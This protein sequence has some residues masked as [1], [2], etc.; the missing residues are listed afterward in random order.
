[1]DDLHNA[2]E[3][4]RKEAV[5]HLTSTK[6][7]AF[8]EQVNLRLD[9]ASEIVRIVAAC[10][11]SV[12][13]NDKVRSILKHR[14]LYGDKEDLSTFFIRYRSAVRL[15]ENGDDEAIT[16]LN[17]S[18]RT[19]DPTSR[20]ALAAE[21]AGS[22]DKRLLPCAAAMLDDRYPWVV[23]GASEAAARMGSVDGI[24][25]LRSLL[26]QEDQCVAGLASASL[27]DV[28][29]REAIPQIRK[30]LKATDAST[31]IHAATALV[32]LGDRSASDSLR[33]IVR[34]LHKDE[35]WLL[36]CS[37]LQRVGECEDI[38]LIQEILRQT[39]DPQV[40]RSACVAVVEIYEKCQNVIK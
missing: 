15:A 5:E 4:I 34:G 2:D 8:L 13:I 28:G 1:M 18:A 6:V 17:N 25:R 30:L 37:S 36:A 10:N 16:F 9:D 26:I 40:R 24:R 3:H 7:P 19:P 22:S 32:S 33:R 23:I 11:K 12:S 27:G 35:E 39:A 20:V 38:S 14:M 29:D 31:R 21:I